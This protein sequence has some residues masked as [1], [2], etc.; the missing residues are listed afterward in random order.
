[1]KALLMTLSFLLIST[2]T[3]GLVAFNKSEIKEFARCGESANQLR[4]F[5]EFLLKKGG[6]EHDFGMGVAA[7]SKKVFQNAKIVLQKIDPQVYAKATKVI[8]KDFRDMASNEG[9]RAVFAKYLP[10]VEACGPFLQDVVDAHD[11]VWEGN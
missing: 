3:F 11:L 5:S 10:R 6:V 7:F 2:N 8:R 4:H 9:A 1:M